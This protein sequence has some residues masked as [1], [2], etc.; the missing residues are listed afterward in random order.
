MKRNFKENPKSVFSVRESMQKFIDCLNNAKIFNEK[1]PYL[2]IQQKEKRDTSKMEIKLTYKEKLNNKKEIYEYIT[3]KLDNL[4]KFSFEYNDTLIKII[5]KTDENL[6][7]S[8]LVAFL[9]SQE[10]CENNT[11]KLVIYIYNKDIPGFEITNS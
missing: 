9:V 11:C 4:S 8:Y 2:V 7:K 6:Y 5:D 10:K 3:K 1:I